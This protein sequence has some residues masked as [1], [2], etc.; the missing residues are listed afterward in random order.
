MG[1]KKFKAKYG[2]QLSDEFC[3]MVV[4]TYRKDWA[5]C[6]PQLWKGLRE[7]S[8]RAVQTKTPQESYGIEYRLEDD[9]LT[10]RLPSGRKIWY[11]HPRLGTALMPW[12]DDDGEPVFR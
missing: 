6:V 12:V 1:W 11:P 5:P 3:Q 2:R 7:A 9:Y 4:N 10:A 8:L